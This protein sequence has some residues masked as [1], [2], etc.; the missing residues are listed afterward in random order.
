MTLLVIDDDETQIEKIRCICAALEYPKIE[1]L[2]ATGVAEGLEI[3][4]GKVVDFVLSDL[5]LLDGSGFEVLRGVKAMNPMIAVAMMTAYADTSEAVQLL[6]EGADDYLIKPTRQEDIEHVILRVNEKVALLHE[7]LLP[8]SDG[9]TASPAVSGIIYRSE[10]MAAM[11]SMAAR[12][13]ASE[14]TVLVTGES[15]TGKE[16]VAR[17]IHDRSARS[18]PFIAVN[19]S[20]FPETLAES[21]LFGHRK[22]AFTGAAVDRI[23]RFEEAQ[24]GTL[25]LDEIGEISP[26]LQVKLLRAI[27]F[28][29][30]E[31]VGEN[32]V[33]SLDVRIVAATNQNLAELVEKGQFRR[34]L[35]YRLNVIEIDLPPIRERRGDIRLLVDHFI[36]RYSQRDSKPIRGIS[37]EALDNL[38]KRPF[39]GNVRELENIIERAVVLCRGDVIRMEDLPPSPEGSSK[40]MLSGG[41]ERRMTDFETELLESALAVSKGNKSAAAREL[42]MT[43]R[44]LRS[45]MERLGL[46]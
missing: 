12:A 2:S 45:R 14:A 6:K 1:Y 28:G 25:F 27:Q 7:A 44:H 8:P 9:P 11:M 23:G 19:I 10:A 41:Y 39:P 20:A 43:E 5:R 17:F 35:Y 33:R 22:G 13:A 40:K 38:I 42:G 15:G 16:L 37:R 32:S 31:R 24:A 4:S 18:G 30:I 3:V 21:E 26:P 34:D 46:L 29:Q 36:Q